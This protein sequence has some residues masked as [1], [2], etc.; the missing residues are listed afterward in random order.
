M[1]LAIII[2]YR[3]RRD[4]L[5][6]FLPHMYEFLSNKQIDY[7]IFV[8]EQ[9]DDRPFNYGKLCNA[10]VNEI[11]D[12]FDYFC[13]HDVD[14][15]P[16][17]DNSEYYPC[18]LPTRIFTYDE[19]NSDVAPYEEY[20]GGVTIFPKETFIKI[21][22]FSNDYWGKGYVDLDILKRLSLNE[23]ELQ[24]TYNYSSKEL[25]ECDLKY[26]CIKYEGTE[27]NLTKRSM[28]ISNNTTFLSGD[29]TVT[30]FYKEPYQQNNKKT[31]FKSYGG[32]D[33]QLFLIENQ[34][35]FQFFDVDNNLYQI[36][37]KDIDVSDNNFIALS[38]DKRNKMFNVFVNGV[39]YSATH[40][41]GELNYN[42]RMVCIGDHENQDNLVIVNFKTHDRLLN[43]VEIRNEYYYGNNRG[44][45]DFSYPCLFGEE[46]SFIDRIG[47]TW[48]TSGNVEIN[49]KPNVKVPKLT[50]L[51]NTKNGSYKI[52]N[53][54]FE[55]LVD[56]Y[57]PDII[58]N[59]LTYLDLLDGRINTERYGLNSIKYKLLNRTDFN[60]LTEWMKI[61]T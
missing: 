37:I 10:V 38:H 24:K 17:N 1:R 45:L 7:K 5:D 15:L 59:K 42:N 41:R 60:E 11:K 34:F 13:F 33:L 14:L 57:D 25:F 9:S 46:F 49:Y 35:I 21:N 28:I 23:I 29:F 31:I 30:L 53:P 39:K 56:T 48:K 2:P 58:E 12:E 32:Y 16:I 6:I 36:D 20:F 52:L 50:T 3:D 26:R 18:D 19:Y 4:E 8:A 55:E 54:K 27:L 47:L 22:G 40:Y 51:P 44:T 61:V 43:D